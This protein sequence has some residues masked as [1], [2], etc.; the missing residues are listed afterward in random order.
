M[1]RGCCFD[2]GSNETA[3]RCTYDEGMHDSEMVVWG[4]KSALNEHDD[5][6]RNDKRASTDGLVESAA[7]TAAASSDGVTFHC[8]GACAAPRAVRSKGGN[9]LMGGH[10]YPGVEIG[11]DLEAYRWFLDRAV[12]GDVLVLTADEP[13]CDIYNLFLLDMNGT[14]TKPN[15]VMTACFTSRAGA[16]DAKLQT[17]LS[18]ASAIFVTGGDQAKYYDFWANTSVAATL[19]SGVAVGGSSA[20]LAIQGEFVFAALHGGV[21]SEDALKHPTDSEVS[22]A[23]AFVRVD[24][25]WM[26]GVVTD[27]H[28]EQR[29]RMGRLVA[30]VARIAQAG[31][32]RA[33]GQKTAQPGVLGVGISEHTALL[34]DAA[35]GVA[36]FV[37]AGPAYLLSSQGRTP[38]TCEEGKSLSWESPGVAVWRWSA[39]DA[40]RN[41]TWSFGS[42]APSD[43]AGGTSYSLTVHEGALASTQKGGGIY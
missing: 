38:T 18:G 21:T 16:S 36:A 43:A 24:E 31:W 5:T 25:P 2:D 13:P 6:P 23:R 26:R 27:T 17:L 8:V 30:F 39:A 34:V 33:D 42:W 12:G 19:S 41:L 3:R 28:F 10:M 1:A 7:T 22:L 35:S 11:T 20:G 14:H 40:A 29:D 37:G 9:A 4:E 32:A 15:S